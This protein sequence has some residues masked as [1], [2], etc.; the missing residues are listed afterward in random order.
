MSVSTFACGQGSLEIPGQQRTSSASP[1][2]HAAAL[3]ETSGGESGCLPVFHSPDQGR[4]HLRDGETFA[5]YNSIPPTSGPHLDTAAEPGFHFDPVA[6]ERLVHN[7][8]HGQ[9]VIWYSPLAE[10]NLLAQLELL[11]EQEPEATVASPYDAVPETFNFVI[12]A[13]QHSQACVLP[14]QEV[15]DAFRTQFQG[16]APEPVTPPFTP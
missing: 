12:T 1:G 6:P 11:V 2:D 14:S 16:H 3:E 7:L 15:M 4:D 5:A 9:V 13:W 10:E 8:E